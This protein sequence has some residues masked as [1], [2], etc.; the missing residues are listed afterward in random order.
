MLLL[1]LFG[2]AVWASK[3]LVRAGAPSA[4][5]CGPTSIANVPGCW[6]TPVCSHVL[7][8]RVEDSFTN[9]YRDVHMSLLLISGMARLVS[10]IIAVRRS[11]IG[12]PIVPC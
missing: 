1:K 9:F 7:Y 11:P 3:I 5:D 4:G 2:V 10:T 8:V 6:G 12:S